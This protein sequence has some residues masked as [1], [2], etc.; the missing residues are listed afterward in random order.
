MGISY[1]RLLFFNLLCK[2]TNSVGSVLCWKVLHAP[3]QNV[4]HK[5]H[6]FFCKKEPIIHK[7][8]ILILKTHYLYSSSKL[9]ALSVSQIILMISCLQ[10]VPFCQ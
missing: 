5:Y 7:Y 2:Q 6:G 1:Y 9:F 3:R 4:S 8:H 10:M